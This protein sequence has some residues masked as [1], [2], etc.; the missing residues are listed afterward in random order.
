MRDKL[1]KKQGLRRCKAPWESGE[2]FKN[3]ILT[4]IRASQTRLQTQHT[5]A[6]SS[7]AE[8][9]GELCRAGVISLTID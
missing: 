9:D 3:D 7:G 5:E 4:N 8:S 2:Y 6:F 1:W